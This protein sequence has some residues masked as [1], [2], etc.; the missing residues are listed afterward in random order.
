MNADRAKST[1]GVIGLGLMGSALAESL[2]A[3]GFAVTVWNRTQAK[4]EPFEAAGAHRA[5]SV[6]EAA[7]RTDV[8]VVCLLEGEV[9][10]GSRTLVVLDLRDRQ[11]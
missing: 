2:L 7:R 9:P 4:A 5:P 3:K 8:L 1:V 6:A 11:P 10:F